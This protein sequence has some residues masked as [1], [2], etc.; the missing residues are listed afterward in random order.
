[1]KQINTEAWKKLEDMEIRAS[2][3]EYLIDTLKK[4]LK[5]QKKELAT[6]LKQMRDL[7]WE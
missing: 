2:H 1:M 4:D 6:I 7:I 5:Q 3:Q